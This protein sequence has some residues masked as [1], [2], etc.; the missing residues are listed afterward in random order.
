MIVS[1]CDFEFVRLNSNLFF[2]GSKYSLSFF[3]HQIY[4]KSNLFAACFFFCFFWFSLLIVFVLWILLW[5][6]L[7]ATMWLSSW[8]LI[9][10]QLPLWAVHISVS[11]VN[12]GAAKVLVNVLPDRWIVS[13]RNERLANEFEFWKTMFFF[14]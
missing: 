4:C 7:S 3:S 5:P 12:F 13:N 9:S 1:L 14:L 10:S 11:V 8:S 2:F 6:L